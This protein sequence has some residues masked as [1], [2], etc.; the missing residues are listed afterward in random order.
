MPLVTSIA[1]PYL[2]DLLSC[3]RFDAE[4]E[5]RPFLLVGA[6]G[7]E[8]R[9]GSHVDGDL[10]A[11]ELC[12]DRPHALDGFDEIVVVDLP[13]HRLVRMKRNVLRKRVAITCYVCHHRCERFPVIAMPRKKKT[14]MTRST[15]VALE[16]PVL[17][18]LDQLVDQGKAKDRS[19]AMNSVVRDYAKALGLNLPSAEIT[20]PQ[21]SLPALKV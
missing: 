11:E 20:A 7:H 8:D 12:F 14:L 13:V 10:V 21:P 9:T 5:G 4:E 6:I 15:G 19:A 2:A 16:V 3:R 1:E 17:E 18:F